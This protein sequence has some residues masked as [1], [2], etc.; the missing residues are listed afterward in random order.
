[1][2]YEYCNKTKTLLRKAI[3]MRLSKRDIKQRVNKNLPVE[4]AKQDI[5]SYSGLE[6]IRRYIK[7]ISLSSTIKGAFKDKNITGDYGI[8]EYILVFFAL[9]L[10]GGRRLNH[11]KFIC[12]D[13]LVQRLCGLRSLPSDRSL[14]SWLKQFTNDSLQALIEVNQEIII[15]KLNDL[16]LPR[17][18]LDFD[19]TVLTCGNKVAWAFK[20]FN[21]SN[22]CAKSYYPI[23][24]HL[25]QTGH[26]LNVKNR[27]GN[28]HDSTGAMGFIQS[29]VNLVREN[30]NA[31]IEAR[32]DSA[33]FRE[34]I[35]KYLINSNLEYALKVPMWECLYLKDKIMER[36]R[37]N[38]ASK[39]LSYFKSTVFVEKWGL[40]LDIIIYRKKIGIFF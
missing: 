17:L 25:S 15:N 5:T 8:F 24:C 22:K 34:D 20:G 18:T 14:S 30:T 2:F 38:R 13:I 6:L 39:N 33:F 31:R 27:R 37:W 26:F 1:M 40:E 29:C 3:F 16:E 21:P 19:G 12:N 35:V 28:V 9:W 10:S 11:V 32:F 23:L 36:K 4:F 7:L